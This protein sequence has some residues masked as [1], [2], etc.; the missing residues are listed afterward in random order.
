MAPPKDK[1]EEGLMAKKKKKGSKTQSQSKKPSK[2][3]NKKFLLREL[4]EAHSLTK[5]EAQEVLKEG[6]SYEEWVQKKEEERQARRLANEQRMI[7][8]IRNQYDSI[9]EEEAR[10]I[11]EEN[12]SPEEFLKRREEERRRLFMERTQAAR[13]R[14][15]KG[16]KGKG[17]GKGKHNRM[18]KEMER[19]A[20]LDE[21]CERYPELTRALAGQL[22]HEGISYEE[23]QR[24]RANK[25]K[26][27]RS[28][29]TEE[30][31][32]RARELQAQRM[33]ELHERLEREAR[34]GATGDGFLQACMDSEQP[35]VV[36]RFHRPSFEG[37]VREIKPLVLVLR[38]E[39]Q[40]PLYLRKLGCAL[41]FRKDE[42]EAIRQ[43]LMV[44]L[45]QLGLLQYPAREPENRY[46][47]PE[48]LLEEGK[49]LRALLHS[50]LLVSGVVEWVDRFQFMLRFPEGQCVFVFKHSVC[51][52]EEGLQEPGSMISLQEYEEKKPDVPFALPEELP[53]E[54]IQVPVQFDDY[55]VKDKRFQQIMELFDQGKFEIHPLRIRREG[56]RYV[57]LDGY[58][59][60]VLAREKEL[61]KVPVSLS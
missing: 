8:L 29:R 24:R 32:E 10:G 49:E 6:I 15:P 19:K 22:L 20:R 26:A 46:Q 25:T 58:R 50:G 14:S 33:E 2:A 56:D 41:L 34:F 12:I 16:Q 1:S 13:K 48:E 52:L 37:E 11:L 21:I 36:L 45:E 38:T 60:L 28:T 47:L 17:K 39:T 35:V 44:D 27:N 54:D 31:H 43:E 61:E 23:Y 42:E 53:L 55:D 40:D 9:S 3:K 57:L 5:E 4:M 30:E 7:S 18:K 51:S 59:R